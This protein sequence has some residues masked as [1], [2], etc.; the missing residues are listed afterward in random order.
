MEELRQRN[1]VSEVF[2]TKAEALE[3]E[4]QELRK[5]LRHLLLV[6]IPNLNDRKQARTLIENR[7]LSQLERS[8]EASSVSTHSSTADESSERTD[9]NKSVTKKNK[10]RR[11]LRLDQDENSVLERT[12]TNSIQDS[13]P[14]RD[15]RA[16]QR[17]R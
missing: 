1:V 12:L 2:K 13:T 4:N 17:K 15:F 8:L 6:E 7:M 9:P 11:R 10:Q 16:T 5:R 3:A 14:I